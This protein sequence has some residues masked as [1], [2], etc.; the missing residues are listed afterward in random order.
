M[1]LIYMDRIT[2]KHACLELNCWTVHKLFFISCVMATKF[3]DDKSYSAKRNNKFYA[4][5][6]GMS[7]KDIN[8]LESSFC[9][10]I[11]YRLYVKTEEYNF[12][13]LQVRTYGK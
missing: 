2:K 10:G 6:G 5:I 9:E 8:F 4:Q 7:V 12:Y 11:D 13:D 3:Q 1:A